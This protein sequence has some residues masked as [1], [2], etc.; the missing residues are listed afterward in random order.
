MLKNNHVPHFKFPKMNNNYVLIVAT[1]L[2]V[3]QSYMIN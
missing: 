2:L 1:M 3:N